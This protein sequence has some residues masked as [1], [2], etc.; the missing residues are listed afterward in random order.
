MSAFAARTAWLAAATAALLLAHVPPT[1]AKTLYKLVDKQGRV[2]YVD[3][4]P[5][6]N[7]DGEVTRIESDAVPPSIRPAPAAPAAPVSTD[8]TALVQEPVEAPPDI[9]KKRRDNRERLQLALDKA[10]ERVEAARKA[11][12]Q[13][14]DPLEGEYQVI[15]QRFD[16]SG[17]KP[18]PRPNCRKQGTTWICA[19][20]VPGEAYRDRQKEL[21]DAVVAAELELENAERA[22][23]R[24]VD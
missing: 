4:P 21:D 22:Y 9:N 16:A 18:G 14:V 6:K 20:Q 24:G 7:F 1:G 10:R 12:D 11:R 2:S 15:Q 13:G 3:K 5:P 17:N 8:G 23:R 19:T